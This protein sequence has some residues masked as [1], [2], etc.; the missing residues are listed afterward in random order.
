MSEKKKERQQFLKKLILSGTIQDQN[1]LMKELESYSIKT[2]QAS[3]S[4]DLKEIGVAKVRDESGSYRYE[5]IENI[6]KGVNWNKLSV[7]FE[8]F[9]V[10][11]RATNNF[12][13]I[14]TTP[15]N[16]NGIASWIDRLDKPE[17]M[18]SIA[19]DDTVL[20]LVDTVKNRRKIEED[21]QRIISR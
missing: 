10:N 17:I 20:I 15:G 13:I 16:A 12:I 1:H 14:K 7:L 18:G 2:T 3:I 9:V 6:S 8:N 21:F 11:I 19:G 5:I 4:R